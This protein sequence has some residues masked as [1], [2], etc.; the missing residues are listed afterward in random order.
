MIVLFLKS[1]FIT[2]FFSSNIRNLKTRKLGSWKSNLI[3][4]EM[5]FFYK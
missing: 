4:L 2:T 1:A 3:G 5:L